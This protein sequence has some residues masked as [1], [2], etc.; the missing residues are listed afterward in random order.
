MNTLPISAAHLKRSALAVLVASLLSG[1]LGAQ[2]REAQNLL[3]L[4]IFFQELVQRYD[5]R[6]L[7][8]FNGAWKVIEQARSMP[9]EDCAS[10]IPAILAAWEHKDDNVKAFAFT[11]LFAVSERPDAGELLGP[12]SKAISGGLDYPSG[13]LQ[14]ATVMLLARLRPDRDSD[15]VP[16]LMS[17]VR[18]ADRHPLAQADALSLLLRIA[19]D[20]PELGQIVERFLARPMD[21]QTKEGVVNDI[22]N[23]HTANVVAV[24]FLIR[25]LEDPKEGVRFQAAQAFQRLP[26]ESVHRA[27]EA[28]SK[29][30]ER[31]EESQE[32]KTAAADSLKSLDRPE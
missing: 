28:L 19:P 24:D 8:D 9:H 26:R 2:E 21:E 32:V 20:N 18:R 22:A 15:A 25:A 30:A 5:A 29:V 10:A 3:S 6:A 4:K 11:A 23:S 7:P 17:F 1:Y 14:G 13:R 27:Q 31:P 16:L 12:Y